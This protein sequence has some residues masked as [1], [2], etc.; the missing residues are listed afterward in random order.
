MTRNTSGFD[1]GSPLIA[2]SLANCALDT[3]TG[4]LIQLAIMNLGRAMCR[5]LFSGASVDI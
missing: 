1:S 3:G 4:P 5:R 2:K